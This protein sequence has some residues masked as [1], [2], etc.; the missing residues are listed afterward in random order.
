M[1]RPHLRDRS[2]ERY[3]RQVLR[4]WRQSGLS[5]RRFC[6]REDIAEPTFY[7]WR[8]EIARRD[9]PAAEAPPPFV[10]IHV[11]PEVA[12]APGPFLDVLLRNGRVVRVAP[13]FDPALLR[14]LLAVAE[15]TPPC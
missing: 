6:T 10:P 7:F 14:Q 5:V 11:R 12:P 13:G 4:R 8:A 3:W 9:Q 2:K 15:E 1:A